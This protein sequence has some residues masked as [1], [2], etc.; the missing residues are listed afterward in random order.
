MYVYTRLPQK[1]LALWYL[2]EAALLFRASL[3]LLLQF[4]WRAFWFTICWN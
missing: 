4:E 3:L 1:I 2:W